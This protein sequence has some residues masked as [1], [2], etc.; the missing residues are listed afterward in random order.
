MKQE[1]Q[2]KSINL[3][4]NSLDF[5][6]QEPGLACVQTPLFPGERESVPDFFWGEGASVH[7]LSQHAHFTLGNRFLGPDPLGS[8]EQCENGYNDLLDGT[9]LLPLLPSK[10]RP[11][12]PP[13][14]LLKV[15]PLS[16]FNAGSHYLGA[17]PQCFL[18]LLSC[19]DLWWFIGAN[20]DV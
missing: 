4:R 6:S 3:P 7:R 18:V 10:P 17:R 14:S 15:N 8:P 11:R 12:P 13:E 19:Y 2:K 16:V 1:F 9:R 20:S 5:S